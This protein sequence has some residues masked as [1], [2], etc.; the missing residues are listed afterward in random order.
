AA[1]S[2]RQWPRA[3]RAC[4]RPRRSSESA[5]NR[6]VSCDR[7]GRLVR[8]VVMDSNQV[9][10]VFEDFFVERG[11]AVVPSSSLIPHHPTAPMFTN[12]GMNQ[13]VPYFLGE[14][15]PPWKRA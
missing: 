5:S 12:A 8:I 4:G 7:A 13:F 10:R 15:R 1:T 14:E 11:H 9:R 2:E 3:G 6:A